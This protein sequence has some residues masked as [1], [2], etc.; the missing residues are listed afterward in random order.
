MVG[1]GSI[2]LW[3]ERISILIEALVVWAS[4]WLIRTELRRRLSFVSVGKSEVV[5]CRVAIF[6]A[7]AEPDFAV[8]AVEK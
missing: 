7:F 2:W 4:R 1:S 8:A 3:S 6:A 5:D